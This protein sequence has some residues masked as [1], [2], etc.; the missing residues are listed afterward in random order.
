MALPKP[1]CQRI[2]VPSQPSPV[3][4][5]WFGDDEHIHLD[6]SDVGLNACSTTFPASCEVKLYNDSEHND[7]FRFRQCYVRSGNRMQVHDRLKRNVTRS[8]VF[9][10]QIFTKLTSNAYHTI[11]TDMLLLLIF[12]YGTRWSRC[13]G[14][15]ISLQRHNAALFISTVYVTSGLFTLKKIRD[16]ATFVFIMKT[17]KTRDM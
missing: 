3:L 11:A 9:Q 7:E 5:P 8:T 10:D 16:T 4:Q 6:V 14:N 17:R 13:I 15:T 2:S 1:H 12:S